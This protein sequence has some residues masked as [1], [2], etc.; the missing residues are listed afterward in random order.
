[1]K[2]SNNLAFPECDSH[3]YK[4]YS[5][6]RTQLDTLELALKYVSKWDLAVDGGAFVGVWSLELSKHF[7]EVFAFEPSH[8]TFECL[9]HNLANTNNV[10][11]L[12]SALGEDN[13]TISLEQDER[14]DGNTGGRYVVSGDDCLIGRLD[15]YH[16]PTLDFIKLDVEGHELYAL[17]GAEETLRKYKPIVLVEQKARLEQRQGVEKNMVGDYL[18]TLGYRMLEKHRKDC[19]YGSNN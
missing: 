4:E 2:F 13:G 11:C 19:I 16:L 5:E 3:M 9:E 12:N 17:K 14:W 1:M 6:G 18:K 8:D 7:N 15:D 10:L